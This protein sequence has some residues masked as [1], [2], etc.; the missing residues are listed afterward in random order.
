MPTPSADDL[1][2]CREALANGSKSFA[3]ASRLLPERVRDPATALYAFCREADDLVDEGGGAPEVEAL[4]GRLTRIA[5][6]EPEDRLV[7]RALAYVVLDH[8]LPIALVDALIDGFAWDAE[9]RRY[10]TIEALHDYGARV[11]A[12]VGAAMTVL[13]GPRDPDTLAR[14]CD[15]GVAMQLTNIARDVGEDAQRG[16]VYLPLDWLAEEGIDPDALI[17]R[18]TFT[19]ALGRVVE[20]LLVEADRLYARAD[21][22]VPRLPSDCRAAVR[23]AARIYASIGDVIRERGGDSVSSRAVV[24][25]WKKAAIAARAYVASDVVGDASAPPLDATR[26][27]V[28]AAARGEG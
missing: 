14:A 26:F 19:P 20:R 2:A 21:L 25:G 28:L 23:A 3:L 16:R 8:D 7:D 27:L 9:N 18:P 6:G 15:L 17:A 4:R 13:M 12:A 22:G 5:R 11:A 10:P 1:R 24:S